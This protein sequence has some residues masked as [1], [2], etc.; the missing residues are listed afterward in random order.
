MEPAV[1]PEMRETVIFPWMSIFALNPQSTQ[2]TAREPEAVP[3]VLVL[4]YLYSSFAWP[5]GDSTRSF[6]PTS[7]LMTFST[8][9]VNG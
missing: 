2:Y 9:G 4:E 5:N 8:D 7:T 1:N 6:G 3:A